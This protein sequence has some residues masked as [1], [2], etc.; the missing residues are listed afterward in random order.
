MRKGSPRS[1]NKAT[2]NLVKSWKSNHNRIMRQL[3]ALNRSALY[4]TRLPIE[5]GASTKGAISAVEEMMF[6][7]GPTYSGIPLNAKLVS[8]PSIVNNPFP[9]APDASLFVSSIKE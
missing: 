7:D 2:N 4:A 6:P 8:K 5:P 9:P 3:G 1:N